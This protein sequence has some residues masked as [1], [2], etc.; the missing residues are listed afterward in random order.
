MRRVMVN[1]LMAGVL[2]LAA[3]A[4]AGAQAPA[5]R[6][7]SPAGVASA[8]VGGTWVKGTDGETY[9]GGKWIDVTYGRPLLR[10]RANI[11]GAGAD[12][13]KKVL[14]LHGGRVEARS[15]G[16]GRGSEFILHIPKRRLD[17]PAPGAPAS[18]A[19]VCPEN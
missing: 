3:A 2:A 17:G 5:S 4:S 16:E 15:A 18:T 8:Q 1:G 13:G 10:G 6:P 19:L 9:Q 12:Y 14:E 7:A 11:F